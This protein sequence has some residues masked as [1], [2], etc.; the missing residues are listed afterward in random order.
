MAARLSLRPIADADREF[1]FRLY[2]STRQDELAVVP[3]SA[4]EKERFLRFQFEAQH[5]YYQEQFA[6]ARFDLVLLDGRPA[7]RLY[8]HRRPDEI[9]LIDI[10]LMP[11]H[12]RRGLGG[13]LMRSVLEEA[14]AAGL[15]VQIHVE[16]NNPAL[17]LYHRLGFVEVE[18]QQPYLLMRREPAAPAAG[19]QVRGGGESG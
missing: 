12:R 19:E 1:L 17:R 16:S 10:A 14:D 11:E 18:H 9:R 13:R 6:D 2:A 8:V 4:E 15:P 5:V 3:W 7:G